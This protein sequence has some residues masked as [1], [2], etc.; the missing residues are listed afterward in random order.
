[1]LQRGFGYRGVFFDLSKA[2]NRIWYE[3]LM[4]KIMFRN[5]WNA[6]WNHMI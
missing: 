1:M 4:Y 3:G 5:M 2:F 6:L